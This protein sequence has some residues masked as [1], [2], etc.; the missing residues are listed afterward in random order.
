MKSVEQF[1]MSVL[2][3]MMA[4]FPSVTLIL[5]IQESGVLRFRF[6]VTANA[7]TSPEKSRPQ[8]PYTVKEIIIK[9]Y[10]KKMIKCLQNWPCNEKP[11]RLKKKWRILNLLIQIT[12]FFLIFKHNYLRG[13]MHQNKT[14]EHKVYPFEISWKKIRALF[15]NKQSGT[16]YR[17]VH[18]PLNVNKHDPRGQTTKVRW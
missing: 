3:L 13:Q 12:I 15:S 6:V 4:S 8:L 14:T 5:T 2:N 11:Q 17:W 16:A 10:D 7:P 9:A 1:M 18:P